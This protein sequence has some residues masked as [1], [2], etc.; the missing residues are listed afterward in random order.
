M[1]SILSVISIVI[2]SK[3]ITSIVAVSREQLKGEV[4]LYRWPPVWLVWNQ[5]Y[6]N[7]QFLFLF[8]K[9][10]N[11]N[12]SNRRSTV[13]WHFPLLCSLLCPWP[14]SCL[15]RVGWKCSTATNTLA[16]CVRASMTVKKS[17]LDRPQK[18]P[19]PST[20]LDSNEKNEMWS[21]TKTVKL[22]TVVIYK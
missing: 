6:Y 8:A 21:V 2:I 12:R 11:P 14:C 18:S 19:H 10:T 20:W 15:N 22:F 16:Y 9:Q 5:L 7:W 3:V 17:L 1:S 4:S 13:Q